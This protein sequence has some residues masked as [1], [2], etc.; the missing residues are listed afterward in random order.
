MI[1]EL[2]TDIQ[3]NPDWIGYGLV[4]LTVA[5]VVIIALYIGRRSGAVKEAHVEIESFLRRIEEQAGEATELRTN[6][7]GLREE[8][9]GLKT[10]IAG[11]E[12]LDTQR[13]E[14]ARAL[15]FMRKQ[16]T[17]ATAEVARLTEGLTR[18]EKANE[19][20][21]ALLNATG[22]KL[23][24]EFKVLAADVMRTH[25][26]DFEKANSERL[27]QTLAPLKDNIDSFKKE[28]RGTQESVVKERAELHTVIKG[29]AEQ[30]LNV[31]EQAH[32][33]TQAL[34]GDSQKQ[35]AWG[36]MVLSHI[37]ESSGLTEG[38]E[39]VTQES[40]LDDE[41]S[42][43]RP[44]V[45]VNF[46]DKRCLIID[47]KVSLK[48]Y[49]NAMA[50]EDADTRA[51]YIAEHIDSVK[52]H[53]KALSGKEYPNL[54]S[55][56]A[57]Y[58]VLFM[59]IESAFSEAVRAGLLDDAMGKNVGLASPSTLTALLRTVEDQWSVERRNRYALRIADEAGKM[60]DKFALFT[61]DMGKL[62]DQ[63]NTAQKSY[64]S[65]MNKLS[66]GRGNLVQR[67]QNLK[68]L[69]VTASKSIELDYDDSEDADPLIPPPDTPS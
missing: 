38:K 39:F 21:V 26:E 48:A 59:P 17:E 34:K 19:E 7:S 67:A 60:Y 37:L 52:R 43:K 30:S 36:E 2:I 62:G 49:N 56:S 68:A 58:V 69:G 61:K 28:L 20:K 6:L 33:L 66:E 55:S 4:A 53:I 14:Q 32:N 45:V 23:K 40:Y 41:N 54:N 12:V 24:S 15:E 29:L 3:K 10:S 63:M 57:S 51:K 5:A 50:T 64:S 44:D 18:Q 11:L 27:K 22:D 46:P 25:G 65:A 9:T 42:R 31:S 1:A 35:G 16:L 8:N 47:S 13:L